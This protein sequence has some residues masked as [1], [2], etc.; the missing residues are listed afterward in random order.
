MRNRKSSSVVSQWAH[1]RWLNGLP[2]LK[3]TGGLLCFLLTVLGAPYAQGEGNILIL[4]SDMAV[5]KYLI[6]QTEFKAQ[7]KQVQAEIDLGKKWGDESKIED[8]ILD[9]DPDVIYCIGSKAYLLAYKLA[10]NKTLVFSS[11]IN[12]QRLPLTKNTYGISNELPP[13]MQLMMSRYFFPN[14]SKIGLLYSE[15]YNKEWLKFATDDAKE[16]GIE[17]VGKAISKPGKIESVLKTLL[18]QVDALWLISDPIVISDEK[19]VQQI[20]NTTAAMKK[21]VFAYSDAFASYGAVLMISV[22][23]PTIGRQAEGLVNEILTEKEIPERVRHPAGSRITIN[24]KKIEEYGLKLN[25]DA[26]DS[27]NKIIR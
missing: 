4:N 25:T 12:W 23:V 5:E 21:P 3:V 19:S 24:L 16:I 13:G 10:K 15:Q 17:I 2:S 27:V 8:V 22:D 26:L 18:P 9:A 11:I 6:V 1:S 20:F 14:V 7:L